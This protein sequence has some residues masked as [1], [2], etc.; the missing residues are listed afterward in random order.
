MTLKR[1]KGQCE[2]IVCAASRKRPGL[3]SIERRAMKAMVNEAGSVGDDDG[4]DDGDGCVCGG[5]VN[6]DRSMLGGMT[7]V[8]VLARGGLLSLLSPLLPPLLPLVWGGGLNRTVC[9]D[10]C[11][12]AYREGD[13]R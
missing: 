5:G 3:F 8:F 4:D 12:M 6:L 1:Q 13:T 9:T 10:G 2:R 11:S 7:I